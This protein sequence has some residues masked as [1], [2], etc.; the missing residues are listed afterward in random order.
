MAVPAPFV[1]VLQIPDG[2]R[3]FKYLGEV[4]AIGPKFRVDLTQ[5]SAD[6]RARP[7]FREQLYVLI[8]AF[9]A[10]AAVAIDAESIVVL[11]AGP[12]LPEYLEFDGTTGNVTGQIQ[13][14]VDVQHSRE[15]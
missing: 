1:T 2:A 3:Y 6:L 10:A 8:Q 5:I 13:V 15:M 7:S 12:A 4:G 11:P 9:D 14:L